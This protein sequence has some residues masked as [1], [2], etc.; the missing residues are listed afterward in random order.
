MK[1]LRMLLCFCVLAAAT[2]GASYAQCADGSSCEYCK[3]HLFLGVICTPAMPGQS[4]YCG[5]FDQ[6]GPCATSSTSCSLT[7]PRPAPSGTVGGR[8]HIV[9]PGPLPWE[10]PSETTACV[11]AANPAWSR[12]TAL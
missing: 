7:A 8:A 5:C 3:Y 4:A 1:T 12:M 6:G 10:V 11:E 2:A 9:K